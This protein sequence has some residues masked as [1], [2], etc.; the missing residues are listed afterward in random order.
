M[1]GLRLAL[2]TVATVGFCVAFSAEGAFS[3]PLPCGHPVM[4]FR[5]ASQ[6]SV[7]YLQQ[8]C[9]LCSPWTV[10]P[11]ACGASMTLLLTSGRWDPS[12]CG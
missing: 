12:F 2:Q 1:S 6:H 11:V 4:G 3:F 7:V 10:C 8:Q 9:S 5:L